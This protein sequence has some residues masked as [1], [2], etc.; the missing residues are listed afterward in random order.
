MIIL[1]AEQ[2]KATEDQF[3]VI[4]AAFEHLCGDL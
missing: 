1:Q 3:L 2:C 4:F